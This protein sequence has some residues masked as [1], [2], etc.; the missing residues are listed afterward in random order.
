LTESV[1][2]VGFSATGSTQAKISNNSSQSRF[3]YAYNGS[4]FTKL[5]ATGW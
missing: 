5:Y 1:D 2:L 3:V 4:S